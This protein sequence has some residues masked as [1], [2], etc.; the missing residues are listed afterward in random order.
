MAK[1]KEKNYCYYS[2]N[3]VTN[4]KHILKKENF[5]LKIKLNIIIIDTAA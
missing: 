2:S 3:L 5:F 4:Q 1:K